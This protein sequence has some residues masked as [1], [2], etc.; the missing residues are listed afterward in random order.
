MKGAREVIVRRNSLPP[1]LLLCFFCGS[2]HLT[3]VP[4]AAVHD[5]QWN[6]HLGSLLK[7]CNHF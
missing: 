2:I 1:K 7:C 3:T 4:W 6:F 5:L